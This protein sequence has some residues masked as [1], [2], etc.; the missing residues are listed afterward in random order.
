M[1]VQSGIIN[2]FS[3]ISIHGALTCNRLNQYSTLTNLCH[4]SVVKPNQ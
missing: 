1:K 4:I 2:D 3:G